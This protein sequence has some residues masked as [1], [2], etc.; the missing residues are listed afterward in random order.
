MPCDTSGTKIDLKKNLCPWN[1]DSNG[2]RQIIMLTNKGMTY[3]VKRQ[4][5]LPQKK[6]RVQD[7]KPW[8]EGEIKN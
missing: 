8:E 1:L 6:S 7:L 2:E 4:Q 3:Y 5:M